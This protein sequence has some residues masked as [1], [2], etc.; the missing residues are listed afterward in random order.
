MLDDVM[1]CISVPTVPH[2]IH[3]GMMWLRGMNPA[4][5]C[6]LGLAGRP[7]SPHFF[8]QARDLVGEMSTTILG[9]NFTER[10]PNPLDT[11]SLNFPR[12]SHDIAKTGDSHDDF[13]FF[14]Y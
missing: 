4:G 3:V 2:R 14:Q 13:P 1:L 6:S 12:K 5:Q 7:P 11:I 9:D 10:E 8:G